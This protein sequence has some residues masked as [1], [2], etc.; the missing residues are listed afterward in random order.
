MEQFGFWVAVRFTRIMM[1]HGL[2]DESFVKGKTFENS[3]D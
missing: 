3:Q 2:R 1:E